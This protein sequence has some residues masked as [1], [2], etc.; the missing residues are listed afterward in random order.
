M[1]GR[2]VLRT[3]NPAVNRRKNMNMWNLHNSLRSRQYLQQPLSLV[4]AHECCRRSNPPYEH[5]TSKKPTR[6]TLLSAVNAYYYYYYSYSYY[7]YYH[8]YYAMQ[9][10]G[11]TWTGLASTAARPFFACSPRH[12][13][14]VE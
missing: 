1:G 9:A 8:Y 14:T 2:N 10:G 6:R 4:P 12:P 7:S 13:A 5:Y 11:A 3:Y